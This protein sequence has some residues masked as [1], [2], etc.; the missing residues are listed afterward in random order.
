MAVLA[1][2]EACRDSAA[3]AQK[4]EEIDYKGRTSPEDYITKRQDHAKTASRYQGLA[5]SVSCPPRSNVPA[6]HLR[7]PTCTSNPGDSMQII[8]LDKVVNLGE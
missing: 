7:P 4:S 3:S 8:L 1:S 5:T 2:F 6:P